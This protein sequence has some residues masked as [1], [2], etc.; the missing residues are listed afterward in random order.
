MCE[1][2]LGQIALF[3]SKRAKHRSPLLDLTS[4]RRISSL[5]PWKVPLV[6][7]ALFVSI[8]VSAQ[9][10]SPTEALALEHQG[11]LAEAAQMWQSLTRQNPRDAAAFASLGVVLSKQQ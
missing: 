5:N 4:L 11:K 1:I 3:Q 8:F 9:T 6:P 10:A 7:L 2:R